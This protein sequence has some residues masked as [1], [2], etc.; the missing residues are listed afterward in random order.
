MTTEVKVETLLQHEKLT[1]KLRM[2]DCVMGETNTIRN[3][4]KVK[5]VNNRSIESERVGFIVSNLL[6][7]L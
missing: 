4:I 5:L 3:R 6:L 1:N 7:L 2:Y